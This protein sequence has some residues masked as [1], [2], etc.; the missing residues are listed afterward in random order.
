MIRKLYSSFSVASLVKVGALAVVMVSGLSAYN[1]FKF[2]EPATAVSDADKEALL[3]EQLTKFNRAVYWGTTAEVSGFLSP[4]IRSKF[5][6]E[7]FQRRERE[8]L[9]S[10]DILNVDFNPIEDKAHVELMIRYYEQP[11]YI[12]ESRKEAQEWKFDRFEGGWQLMEREFQTA[13]E[14]GSDVTPTRARFAPSA[15]PQR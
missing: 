9:V 8:R 4:Q 5:L 2:L 10:S 6:N 14:P 15:V 13:S 12:V 7:E 11:R 3:R 1:S